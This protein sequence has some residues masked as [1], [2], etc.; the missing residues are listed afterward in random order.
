M[1]QT[2]KKVDQT[3]LLSHSP[4][5]YE[6]QMVQLRSAEEFD[7]LPLTSWN[8]R[9]PAMEQ[10]QADALDSGNLSRRTK[11]AMHFHFHSSGGLHLIIVPGLAFTQSGH[12]L[13]SGRGYY[14][15]YFQKALSCSSLPFLIGLAFDQQ[16]LPLLPTERFDVTLDQVI[17]SSS[18]DD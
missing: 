12:R 3:R 5:S 8:M 1:N 16:I 4:S 15:R 17:T 6:M 9:Q 11:K 10:L 7:S 14:D 13:G 2:L 18:P